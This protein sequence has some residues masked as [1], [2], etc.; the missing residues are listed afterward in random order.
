VHAP[1]P[2]LP[3][4]IATPPHE[5]RR[6]PPVRRDGE[7]K[8]GRIP[9]RGEKAEARLYL[10]TALKGVDPER[11]TIT[12][13]SRDRDEEARGSRTLE[14]APRAQ[15]LLLEDW[16]VEGR[17]GPREGRLSDLVP[18]MLVHVYLD[19]DEKTV[20]RLRAE[21][22]QERGLL[23]AVDAEGRTVTL[24]AEGRQRT[25]Q[26]S[27]EGRVNLDGRSVT[28]AELRTGLPVVVKLMADRALA[29]R[30]MQTTVRDEG[31]P[32]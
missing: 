32:R 19:D 7:R 12:V 14:L 6:D 29:T 2:E 28:L 25:C 8:E 30:V 15:V 18:G 26:V 13:S 22:L 11:R 4:E 17:E 9:D 1:A 3:E 5:T 10:R 21:P 20:V 31:R 16:G 27:P 24:M 23:V